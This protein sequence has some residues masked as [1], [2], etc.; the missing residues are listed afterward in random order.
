MRKIWFQR[1]L[2]Q[3]GIACVIIAAILFYMAVCN[4]PA[5]SLR[6]SELGVCIE[7]QSGGVKWLLVALSVA[8]VGGGGFC[9]F[10]Y[11]RE[12]KR[13]DRDALDDIINNIRK[14]K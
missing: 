6:V 9:L 11:A 1:H 12:R 14:R 7:E 8:L 13:A 5:P 3:I 10:R 4:R 2:E